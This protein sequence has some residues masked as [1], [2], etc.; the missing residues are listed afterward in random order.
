MLKKL[1]E[2]PP[3]AAAT[4]IFVVASATIIG[5]LIFEHVLKFEACEL[6]YY[7]RKAWYFLISFG[8]LMVFLGSKGSERFVRYGLFFSGLLLLGEAAFAFWH[9][10][11]EWKWWPGPSSCTGVT[12]LTGALPDLSRKVVLCD[13]APLHILGLSLAGWNVVISLAT[14]AVAFRGALARK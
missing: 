5:A 10:G 11:I 1:L 12:N 14:A 8:L 2:S 4:I 6:C 13:E 9:A 7:Q 3:L